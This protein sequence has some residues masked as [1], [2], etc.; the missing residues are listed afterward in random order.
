MQE[1]KPEFGTVSRPVKRTRCLESFKSELIHCFPMVFRKFL[2]RTIRLWL[3]ILIYLC[4]TKRPENCRTHLVFNYADCL[5]VDNT[6]SI[7]F[8]CVRF[9][10]Y[11]ENDWRAFSETPYELGE[12]SGLVCRRIARETS[13]HL[14]NC[15]HHWTHRLYYLFGSRKQ[16]M[17]TLKSKTRT[18]VLL[19]LFLSRDTSK[20]RTGSFVKDSNV[21]SFAHWKAPA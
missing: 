16:V 1:E 10:A 3:L 7:F 20:Q 14:D 5:T 2:I 11:A 13:L 8:V 4:E 17:Q 19:R 9:V 21:F 18:V 12:A 6:E 15:S